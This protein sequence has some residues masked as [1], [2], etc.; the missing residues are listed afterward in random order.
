MKAVR[1]AG[2]CALAALVLIGAA[3]PG[4]AATEG[5]DFAVKG[6]GLTPC[7]RFIETLAEDSTDLLIIAGWVQ[8]YVTSQNQTRSGTFD[9]MPWQD[10]S[11]QL[12]QLKRFCEA[13]PE[14]RLI[15]AVAA[16]LAYLE[17]YSLSE[18]AELI[19]IRPPGD[20]PIGLFDATLKKAQQALKEQG[21][22]DGPADG[23]WGPGTAEAFR[24]F[25][26]ARGLT[27]TGLPDQA[28]LSLLL[29]N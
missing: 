19:R 9:L 7:P 22:L 6:A 17:R 10:A 21:H 3:G 14:Q 5:G 18:A 23:R 12:S 27:V 20:E 26:R 28:S 11:W 13:R 15:D 25:Q 1:T 8:G 2:A 24:S 16:L 29:L 4:R